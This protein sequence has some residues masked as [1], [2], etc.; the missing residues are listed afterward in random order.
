MRKKRSADDLEEGEMVPQKGTKQ[1]KKSKDPKDKKDKSVESRKKA[2]APEGSAPG[3]FGLRWKVSPF[4]GTPRSGSPKEGMPPFLS[5]PYS[6]LSFSP[7]IWKASGV[8]NSP[9]SLCR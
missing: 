2:E 5:R 9:T 7:R 6:S 1:Q 3:P 4:P 8:P